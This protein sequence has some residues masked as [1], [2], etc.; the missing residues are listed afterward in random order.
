MSGVDTTRRPLIGRLVAAV[1]IVVAVFVI[2]DQLPSWLIPP[3]PYRTFLV[4]MA[5]IPAVVLV[6]TR[7]RAAL[8][9]PTAPWPPPPI[10]EPAG[11]TAGWFLAVVGLA[12]IPDVVLE[13]WW[14]DLPGSDRIEWAPIFQSVVRAPVWEELVW[15]GIALGV[16]LR[17]LPA[18]AAI[19]LT[20]AAFALI[21]F[22]QGYRGPGLA[23]TFAIGIVTGVAAWRTGTLW[24]PIAVHALFNSGIGI[25]V[26]GVTW[27]VWVARHL[28]TEPD[29]FQRRPRAVIAAVLGRTPPR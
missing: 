28:R 29:G 2:N 9:K 26:I 12:V 25:V 24:L 14:P 7:G 1:A 15:R 27:V 23:A 22:E 19:V 5:V 13:R 17:L 20:A 11:R 8:P 3:L 21:H 4:A 18:R 10:L 16:V 6:V